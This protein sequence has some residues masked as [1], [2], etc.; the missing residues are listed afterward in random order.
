VASRLTQQ[1][2]EV[3]STPAP[4]ARV[5]Q[6]GVEVLTYSGPAARWTQAAVEVTT[7]TLAPPRL[8][9]HGLEVL[10]LSVPPTALPRFPAALAYGAQGGPG[11]STD[12]V[13]TADGQESRNINWAEARC[14]WDVGSI[15]RS[16]VEIEILMAFF[17]AAAQ[18]QEGLFLFR[19][20][21]D[22]TFDNV[23]GVGDGSTAEFQLVKRYA[24]GPYAST[25]RLTHPLEGTVGVRVE[26]ALVSGWSLD[27]STGLLTLAA[28]PAAGVVVSAAGTFEVLCRFAQD[29]L[30]VTRVAP[31]AYSCGQIELL[32]VRD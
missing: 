22:D 27:Y 24:T 13:L 4:P 20:F 19:D 12:V 30:P 5:T 28:A 11:F 14:R 25:R 9:Q 10:W 3:L 32:E 17:H 16:K 18:G 2:L 29:V 31:D 15:H 21:T 1:G 6:H 7:T 26:G 8:T 23:I